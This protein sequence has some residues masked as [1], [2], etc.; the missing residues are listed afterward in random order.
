MAMWWTLFRD[1]NSADAFSQEVER[2]LGPATRGAFDEPGRPPF[3]LDREHRIRDLA[4]WGGLTDLAADIVAQPCTLST[5]QARALYG[6]MA[7]ILRRS[8]D[9]QRQL[10]DAIERVAENRFGGV[11]ERQFVTA[12][13]TGRKPDPDYA[14][15]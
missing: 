13:Y 14:H 2:I 15:T 3:Q 1:P 9:E 11:V 7:S 6:S 5:A 12:M 8:P 4:T 10:L